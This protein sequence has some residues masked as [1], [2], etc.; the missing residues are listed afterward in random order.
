MMWKCHKD[1]STN[2]RYYVILGRDLFTV[3]GLYLKFSE[4]V[5]R[6]GEIPYEGCLAP[7]VDVNNYDFNIVTERIFKPEESFI[8]S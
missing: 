3:L 6:G 4:N 1:E 2:G 7:I 5:I 8:N